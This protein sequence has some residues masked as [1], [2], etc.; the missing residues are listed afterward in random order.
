MEYLRFGVDG[1]STLTCYTASDAPVACGSA[2]VAYYQADPD[3][4]GALAATKVFSRNFNAR[5][6]NGNAVLRWEY[7]PGS[8]LFFVWTT[9]CAA[10]ESDPRFDAGEN[11]RQLC[12]GPSDNVFAV[13]ATYWIGK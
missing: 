13:K 7:R 6:L 9:R 8:S 3:G 12:Q 10:G 11:L 5:S 1:S 4:A 2:D